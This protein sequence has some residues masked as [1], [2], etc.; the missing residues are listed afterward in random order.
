MRYDFLLILYC[1]IFHPYLNILVN[2]FHP[3]FQEWYSS[4]LHVEHTIKVGEGENVTAT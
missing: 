2:P 4:S 3:K 1:L